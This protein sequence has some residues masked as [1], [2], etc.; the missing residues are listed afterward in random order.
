MK[1]AAALCVIAAT[2]ASAEPLQGKLAE[3]EP[4]LGTWEVRGQWTGGEAVWARALFTPGI[5]GRCVE[6]RVLVKDGDGAPYPRYFTVFTYDEARGTWV[7][8]SFQGDGSAKDIDFKL[9]NGV[10]TTRWTQG[11]AEILDRTELLE[12]GD[13][14]RW[15][16]S[17]APAGTDGF[18]PVL[19]ATWIR[20]G[21]D[22]MRKPIDANLFS[23]AEGTTSF[24]CE[25]VIRAPVEDV[26]RAWTD[27]KAFAAAYGPD[28]PEL[29]GD[30]DLAIG[31]RYEWL[32]DGVTGSNDC[33]VLSF[34]PGRMVSF[35]WN[36]PPTQPDSRAQRTWV[37]VET[38]P[39]DG[40]ATHVRLTHLGFGPEPHWVE[41][42]EYFQKAWPH[43]LEQFRTNLEAQG[44]LSSAGS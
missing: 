9:E 23:A 19:D 27:G 28:R 2:N 18:Q 15:T 7:G 13:R 36:A 37:V 33:Q 42:R 17:M 38:S 24:V 44:G 20:Q 32:W 11:G 39:A 5:G 22:E 14:M 40:G 6:G 43:V 21:E 10:M 35:S 26:Y 8:N 16:V 41:T 1:L 29:G 25:A 4:W 31:G 30:I 34:I 3:L 12:G